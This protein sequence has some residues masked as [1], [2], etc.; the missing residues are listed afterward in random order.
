MQKWKHMYHQIPTSGGGGHVS[1]PVQ[2]APELMCESCFPVSNKRCH[3]AWTG[4]GG[5]Q[6]PA[7]VWECDLRGW[8]HVRLRCAHTVLWNSAGF[9]T[10]RFGCSTAAPNPCEPC[11]LGEHRSKPPRPAAAG[12]PE[13]GGAALPLRTGWGPLSSRR[14]R[15]GSPLHSPGPPLPPGC[16]SGA[17]EGGR[18]GV[19][20]TAVWRPPSP[21]AEGGRPSPRRGVAGSCFSCCSN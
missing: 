13:G 21:A 4:R 5:T 17:A 18:E 15:E 8:P 10:L 1:L 7:R 20:A 11:L 2:K 3:P 9:A 19:G 12:P 16:P 14:R 6:V